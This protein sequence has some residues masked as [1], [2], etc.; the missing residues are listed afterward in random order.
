MCHGFGIGVYVAYLSAVRILRLAPHPFGL[1]TGASIHEIVQVV[2]ATF[3]NGPDAGNFGTIAKLSRVML[4]APTILVLGYSAQNASR[5]STTVATNGVQPQGC[6][7]RGS[8][9]ASLRSCWAS[10]Q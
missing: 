4:L 5:T 6:Q 1:W 3:Q 9:W 7:C 2:A 8:C 10:L